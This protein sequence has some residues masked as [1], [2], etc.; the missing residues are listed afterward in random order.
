MILGTASYM[1]PEQA[2]GKPIDKRADVWAFGC[3]M[4]ELLSGRR[5]FPGEKFSDT[6]AAILHFE[7]DWS[8]LPLTMPDR[9]RLLL[10]RCLQKDVSRR[11]R[12]AGDLRLELDKLV[13]GG[14]LSRS[15]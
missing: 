5:A 13:T 3:V 10:R 12:D 9:L 6:V 2:R 7:P 15:A 8:L 4:Y 11:L 14:L 1:S